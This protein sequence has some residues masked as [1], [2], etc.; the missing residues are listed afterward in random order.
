MTP[1]GQKYKNLNAL[2]VWSRASIGKSTSKCG[3]AP[4]LEAGGGGPG[5]AG[6]GGVKT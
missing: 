2:R 6:G 1:V 4:G 3:S 5:G